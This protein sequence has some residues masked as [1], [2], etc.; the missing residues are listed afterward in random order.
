MRLIMSRV[1]GFLFELVRIVCRSVHRVSVA[2]L[3]ILSEAIAIAL[4]R[5]LEP[6]IINLYRERP[7]LD[8]PQAQFEAFLQLYIVK[9][10]K[11]AALAGSRYHVKTKV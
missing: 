9:L 8:F 3:V 10:S 11:K 5:N 1:R 6:S 7:Y 4:Y 2:C